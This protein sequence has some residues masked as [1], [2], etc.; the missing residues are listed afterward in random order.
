MA[1]LSC[2]CCCYC[3]CW[4]RCLLLLLLFWPATCAVVMQK[5]VLCLPS[6]QFSRNMQTIDGNFDLH[7]NHELYTIKY[8]NGQHT[9]GLD[10]I[11]STCEPIYLSLKTRRTLTIL[12]IHS[13]YAFLTKISIYFTICLSHFS[14][15]LFLLKILKAKIKSSLP[16]R[17]SSS[18]YYSLV[19]RFSSVFSSMYPSDDAANRI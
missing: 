13:Q 9:A 7:R 15:N 6:G 14:P 18:V 19:I 10:S 12:A 8:T 1:A 3:F 2:C 4:C 17:L 11:N 5:R 16:S